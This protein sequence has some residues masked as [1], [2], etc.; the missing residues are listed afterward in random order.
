ML[1][2]LTQ[3]IGALAEVRD[4]PEVHMKQQAALVIAFG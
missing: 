4:V 1:F 3:V 2:T